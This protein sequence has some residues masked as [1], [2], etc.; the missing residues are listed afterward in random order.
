MFIKCESNEL[1]EINVMEKTETDQI[2][3]LGSIRLFKNNIQKLP[4]KLKLDP[5]LNHRIIPYDSQLIGSLPLNIS[6]G[7]G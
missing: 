6:Q 4:Y 5:K 1:L 3:Q 7:G 2:D